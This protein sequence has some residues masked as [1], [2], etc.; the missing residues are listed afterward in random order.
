MGMP[1]NLILVR[2]GESEGN[3]ANRK[4]RRGD[5]SHFT[6][7][8]LK[9]HSSNWALTERGVEQAKRAGQWIRDNFLNI[10]P[11]PRKIDGLFVSEFL[12]TRQT[13]G[14]MALNAG[15]WKINRLIVERDWGQMDSMPNSLRIKKYAKVIAKRLQ[16]MIFWRPIGG[17]R[18]IDL[19]VRIRI[20]FDTLH[21]EYDGKDVIV[22]AHGEVIE[23]MQC[24]LERMSQEE[25]SAYSKDKS[26]EIGNCSIVH[27][28]RL[29]TTT[30]QM[31]PHFT[32]VRLIAAGDPS[33]ASHDW[34]PI[35]FKVYSD[36]ELLK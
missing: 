9:V 27:Y 34:R 3:V 1:K 8:F 21:R 35:V 6:E 18:L 10:G 23:M 31:R 26:R 12:R 30:C 4:S 20:F 15:N 33:K 17:E 29:D 14:H 25:F 19:E 2:H 24:I 5:D 7:D 16:A 28:T 22:V 36:E 11:V 32:A 13:A